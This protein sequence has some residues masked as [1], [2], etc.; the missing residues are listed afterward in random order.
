MRVVSEARIQVVDLLLD[1]PEGVH[2]DELTKQSRLRP[3]KLGPILRLLVSKH[4]FTEGTVSFLPSLIFGNIYVT[5]K[6]TVFAN[7]RLSI[8]LLSP[9]LL[10]SLV[11]QM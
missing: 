8:K 9:D 6:P 4:C 11:C 7:N 10:N 5:V 2:V 3:G 1:K